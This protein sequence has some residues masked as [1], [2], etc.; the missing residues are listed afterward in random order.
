MSSTLQRRW[1]L[2]ALST[3]LSQNKDKLVTAQE[4]RLMTI[5]SRMCSTLQRRWSMHLKFIWHLCMHTSIHK[6]SSASIL[7]TSLN[8]IVLDSCFKISHLQL[9]MYMHLS[10]QKYSLISFLKISLSSV[11]QLC[12]VVSFISVY[13][14]LNSAILDSRVEMNRLQLRSCMHFLTQ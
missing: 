5:E 3:K 11:M 7:Y 6:H 1:S 4:L 12:F 14:S 10:V 8:S 2:R 13:A 9:H